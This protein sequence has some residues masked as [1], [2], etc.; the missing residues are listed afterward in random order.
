MTI[1]NRPKTVNFPPDV[2]LE[3]QDLDA[4]QDAPYTFIRTI[5][6]AM[7]GESATKSQYGWIMRGFT[8]THSTTS[9]D[10]QLD[11]VE[12]IA[13][14][15]DGNLV[16][17]SGGTA[18]IYTLP[19]ST[20]SILYAYTYQEKNTQDTRRRWDRS[21]NAEV[22]FTD[23]TRK[24]WKTGVYVKSSTIIETHTEVNG[25]TVALLPIYQFKTDGAGVLVDPDT[26]DLRMMWGDLDDSFITTGDAGKG[27]GGIRETFDAIAGMIRKTHGY[28]AW[29]TDPT[30]DLKTVD[31]EVIN[32][33][34]DVWSGVTTYSDL[35][36]GLRSRKAS[37]F[38]VESDTIA[39]GGD[40]T[41][42]NGLKSA[43]EYFV[44]GGVEQ[45]TA[46]DIRLK[47]GVFQNVGLI[48][49]PTHM[50]HLTGVKGTVAV[51]ASYNHTQIQPSN[52]SGNKW[53]LTGL[54]GHTYEGITFDLSTHTSDWHILLDNA[55][56]IR[57]IDCNFVVGASVTAALIQI[58]ND[59]SRITFT[60]CNFV[61]ASTSQ[62][63]IYV[64]SPTN[65][66]DDIRFMD[67]SFEVKDK[68]I[69]AVGLYRRMLV[70]NSKF[71]L[72]A[73]GTS[74]TGA[75]DLSLASVAAQ[76]RIVRCDFKDDS[77][78]AYAHTISAY[79]PSNV[80]GAH[81]FVDIEECT[82][83]HSGIGLKVNALGTRSRVSDCLFT[84]KTA[85]VTSVEVSPIVSADAAPIQVLGCSFFSDGLADTV[86]VYFSGSSGS[87]INQPHLV[88]DNLFFGQARG[89]VAPLTQDLRF[90]QIRGNY[91]KTVGLP[92]YLSGAQIDHVSITGNRIEGGG[93]IL[94][95]FA[96]RNYS[97]AIF[98]D[99]STGSL[100]NIV[101]EGN[102]VD[103]FNSSA[104]S[105]AHATILCA[106]ACNGVSV[107]RNTL[108]SCGSGNAGIATTDRE[109]SAQILLASMSTTSTSWGVVVS[110]NQISTGGHGACIY[111]DIGNNAGNPVGFLRVQ[112]EGNVLEHTLVDFWA[113]GILVSDWLNPISS[114]ADVGLDCWRM[115]VSNNNVDVKAKASVSYATAPIDFYT[116]R[117]TV[118]YGKGHFPRSLVC[119]GNMIQG[120]MTDAVKIATSGVADSGGFGSISNNVSEGATG[121][122]P[123]AIPAASTRWLSTNNLSV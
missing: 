91:F 56:D 13:F 120:T 104:T 53:N 122:S 11:A 82:I 115:V 103:Q 54:S 30:R 97:T 111:L 27:I 33:R 61:S 17:R 107:L 51:G 48:T 86:G 44:V 9:L 25:E 5:V 85:N 21:T 90:T 32:A 108:S 96:S 57:F 98:V 72:Q 15:G 105:D 116:G 94:T 45:G 63:L 118:D 119:E 109:R 59:A 113:G 102:T 28:T 47:G 1:I 81:S 38:T 74:V 76:A 62:P 70:E 58:T 88:T 100:T 79:A 39:L 73:G 99:G 95:A 6:E 87:Q 37:H 92:I 77:S 49:P 65:G 66:S 10:V 8:V 68:A 29:D 112:I 50:L 16:Y 123:F 4:L 93:G 19:P 67:C 117:R 20:T 3:L 2:R 34:K 121:A 26:K 80:V 69:Q 64:N 22:F 106:G 110:H 41:G 35:Q 14:D 114:N 36:T 12:S 43:V 78:G 23:D 31:T 84:P 75:I 52:S 55:N 18:D 46:H 83:E 24:E 40:F 60:R 101:I 89:I 7:L 71:T 42:G